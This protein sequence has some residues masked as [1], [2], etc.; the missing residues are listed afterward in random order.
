MNSGY[1]FSS[2][3]K[4]DILYCNVQCCKNFVFVVLGKKA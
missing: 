2:I 1:L 3:E 4:P